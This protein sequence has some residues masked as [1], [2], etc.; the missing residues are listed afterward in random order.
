MNFNFMPNLDNTDAAE[1]DPMGLAGESNAMH[2]SN[3]RGDD[4]HM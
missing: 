2:M 3:T 1:G 4:E